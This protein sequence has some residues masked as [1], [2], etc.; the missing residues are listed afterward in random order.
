[1]KDIELFYPGY[2]RKAITFSIDDGN[3]SYDKIFL[4]TV[5]PAGIKGTFNLTSPN[6]ATPEE[7]R[8]LYDGYEIANHCKYH[9]YAFA[10]GST[11]N[12]S[13]MPFDAEK[14]DM[15]LIYKHPS[16]DGLYYVGLPRG[17]RIITDADTYI[18]CIK[19]CERELEEIF[20]EGSIRSFAWPFGAQKSGRIHDYLDGC[21]YYAV[22][23]SGLA[24]DTTGFD[25]PESAMGWRCNANHSNLLDQI[26]L[27][28]SYPDDGRLKFFS[29]GV[30][31]ADFDRFDKWNELKV[32]AEKYGGRP[33]DF[34]Y[35]TVGEIFDYHN[36]KKALCEIDGSI[37][38]NSDITLY[39]SIDGERV[40]IPPRCSLPRA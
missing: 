5:R 12:I 16:V 35:A 29:F 30:H 37:T 8:A 4:D 6:R 31:S 10:D 34:W 9:P 27:Y 18:E 28:E 15:S 36:A 23:Q 26:A 1:M 40:I 33:N 24:L 39:L 14:S 3:I 11:Y 32:F 13:D 2:T 21:G 22:R 17:W 7:Y 20:G 19:A 38:N 25:F